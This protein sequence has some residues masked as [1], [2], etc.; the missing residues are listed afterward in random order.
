MIV[1]LSFILIFEF[2]NRWAVL[3]WKKI[4]STGGWVNGTWFDVTRNAIKLTNR[5]RLCTNFAVSTWKWHF[6]FF[7]KI[8]AVN[9]PVEFNEWI[10]ENRKMKISILFSVWKEHPF[11]MRLNWRSNHF[12]RKQPITPLSVEHKFHFQFAREN[13][14]ADFLYFPFAD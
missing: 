14:D 8:F 12:R 9:K 10:D 2:L 11:L 5:N 3:V 13:F 1:D 7:Y 4:S 6:E